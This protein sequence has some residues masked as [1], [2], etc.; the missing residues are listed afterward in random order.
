MEITIKK[1]Y[2]KPCLT[3]IEIENI[4]LNS[5]SGKDLYDDDVDESDEEAV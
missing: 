5:V 4:L 3:T 2:E 1:K